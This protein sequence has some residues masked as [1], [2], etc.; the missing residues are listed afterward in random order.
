VFLGET[1]VERRFP[2][3][4]ALTFK[5][6]SA[7]VSGRPSPWWGSARSVVILPDYFQ[8]YSTT[9]IGKSFLSGKA[10][11]ASDG[12]YNINTQILRKVMIPLPPLDE[13]H[14][15]VSMVESVVECEAA[16]RKRSLA[17]DA[18]FQSLLHNLMTGK[19]RVHDVP[20]FARYGQKEKSH[21]P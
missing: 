8:M 9:E 15:L 21:E 14:R 7:Y 20:S 6:P 11:S 1:E 3:T 16:N 5:P 17:L 4:Q 10:S 12:K 19:V 2:R 18:L 13:Q